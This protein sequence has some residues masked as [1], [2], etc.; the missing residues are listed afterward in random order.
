MANGVTLEEAKAN[1]RRVGACSERD[2]P[3]VRAPLPE[4]VVAFNSGGSSGYA[5]GL[6]LA[7]LERGLKERP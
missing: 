1:F 7:D 2:L 4:E 6:D 5:Y 3:H